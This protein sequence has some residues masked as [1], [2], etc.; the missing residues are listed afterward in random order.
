MAGI[1]G[2]CKPMQ[3]RKFCDLI[4]R[5]REKDGFTR[6]N[7]MYVNAR[8]LETRKT[9]SDLPKP[10]RKLLIHI[11]DQWFPIGIPLELHLN[12]AIDLL[13][14]LKRKINE[15]KMPSLKHSNKFYELIPHQGDCRRR[16]RFKDI[17]L[18]DNKIK[19]VETM[20]TAID[21]LSKVDRNRRRN[22]LDCFIEEWMRIELRVLEP[23]ENAFEILSEVVKNTQH[24]NSTRQFSIKN[25]FEVSNMN[26]NMNGDFSSNVFVN[27]RYLF[28]FSFASNLP[29]ILR[30]GLTVAPKHI[31][32]INRFLGKGIYFWD[33]I[34]NSG[35][36]YKSLN[37]VYVLVCKVAM[38]K[39]Q[40]VEQQYLKLDE[41]LHWEDDSDSIFCQGK[42]FSSSRDNEKDL[43]GI[44]IYCG[45]LTDKTDNPID[46]YSLYNEYVVRN[47][48][49]VIVD[50]II[51]LEKK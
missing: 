30:E 51:K 18:C 5:K 28:H 31:H 9:E 20:K 38:G 47:K 13:E 19:Y 37:T 8:H 7:L 39:V 40:Q 46:R 6:L 35:L 21:C 27:H 36:N 2:L 12:R 45:Q 43:N 4:H 41:T 33:A 26:P 29:C 3:K 32:S 48:N 25:I 49:Q 14:C 24:P 44:Q 15:G 1:K 23:N 10:V 50:Y 16:P 34:E 42:Q 11:I 22:P 17:E